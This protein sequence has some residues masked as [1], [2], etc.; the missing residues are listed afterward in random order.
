MTVFSFVV[1]ALAV[2]V[3][4]AVAVY[5]LTFYFIMRLVRGHG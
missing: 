1:G 4:L 3:A 2:L 5:L